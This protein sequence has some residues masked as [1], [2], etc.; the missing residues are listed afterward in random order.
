MYHICVI[1]NYNILFFMLIQMKDTIDYS[2][3]TFNYYLE[4][5][6]NWKSYSSLAKIYIAFTS[7]ERL[8]KK[9]IEILELI[10]Q[11]K[12]KTLD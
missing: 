9:E 12:L 2:E 10:Y 3:K 5:I 4:L 1:I 7:D 11:F 8:T 6:R